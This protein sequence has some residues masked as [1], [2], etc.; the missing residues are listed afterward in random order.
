MFLPKLIASVLLLSLMTQAV[1][2]AI[3]ATGVGVLFRHNG[4]VSFGH[5]AFYGSTAY[6]IGLSMRC[7]LLSMELAILAA[8]AL[9]SLLAFILGPVIARIPGVAFAMLTLAVGQAFYEFAL[10]ARHITVG[11][12]G[13]SAARNG[14]AVV[15]QG[16]CIIPNLT[17]EENLLLGA[18]VN[19]PG[20]WNLEKVYELF[21]GLRERQGSAGTA[22]SG[23]QQ[24][25]LAIGR[26]HLRLTQ[27]AK[28]VSCDS[29]FAGLP[30]W[31][32]GR[33]GKPPLSRWTMSEEPK[34]GGK[35][36][37]L[38]DCREKPASGAIAL[39]PTLAVAAPA[40][41]KAEG[42]GGQ[43]PQ[44]RIFFAGSNGKTLQYLA[45]SKP[46]HGEFS[47]LFIINSKGL[48]L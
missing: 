1:I 48:L 12:D 7:D 11:D 29:N 28:L 45:A 9:P 17:V 27:P 21:P 18:A 35:S 22:L 6:I 25:M 32:L 26:A 16:R 5:A 30:N 2:G 20:L 13:F 15:P 33:F 8:L 14:I 43:R 34:G 42:G 41:G 36:G 39:P 23:G 3:T 44:L 46:R 37:P 10:K 4:V 40:W 19:R 24:Q 47:W 38:F 31:L